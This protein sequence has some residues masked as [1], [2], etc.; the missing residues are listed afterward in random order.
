MEQQTNNEQESENVQVTDPLVHILKFYD[1]EDKVYIS[2]YGINVSL[3][4]EV[5]S[6]QVLLEDKEKGEL[7]PT[8]LFSVKNVKNL[9]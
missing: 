8:K 5:I 3:N 1:P 9:V 7:I 4:G 6:F 2:F